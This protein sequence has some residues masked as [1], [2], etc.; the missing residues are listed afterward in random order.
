MQSNGR[1]WAIFQN[2]ILNYF[3]T[4]FA[5]KWERHARGDMK[6][7]KRKI[8]MPAVK[9]TTPPIVSCS[10]T[11]FLHPHPLA[12]S[13]TTSNLWPLPPPS[14][15]S[16]PSSPLPSVPPLAPSTTKYLFLFYSL[17]LG[18]HVEESYLP[19][20][21]ATPSPRQPQHSICGFRHLRAPNRLLFFLFYQNLYFI[22][23]I[24]I[25]ASILQFE[26]SFMDT[27]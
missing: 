27:Y 24:F 2:E 4:I 11:P 1:T 5:L 13:H 20:L 22:N 12:I 8:Y 10:V 16:S 14:D 6:K 19:N 26:H 7:A 3:I 25:L 18:T 17:L 21:E 23:I 9:P 15:L